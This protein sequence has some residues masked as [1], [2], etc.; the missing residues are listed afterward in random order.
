MKPTHDSLLLRV[1]FLR[2]N[3]TVFNEVNH[4]QR[5]SN[6]YGKE[7]I[8]LY[9]DD[10]LAIFKNTSGPQTERIRKNVTRQFKNHGLKITIQT[11]LKIVN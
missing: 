7:S 1:S 11:N 2:T 8:G 5:M 10:G 6:E 3:Q 9:R 4:S